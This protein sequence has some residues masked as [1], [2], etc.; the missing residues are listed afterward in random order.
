MTF[1]YEFKVLTQPVH[2]C[3]VRMQVKSA[4]VFIFTWKQALLVGDIF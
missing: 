4:S 3:I 2:F 1:R